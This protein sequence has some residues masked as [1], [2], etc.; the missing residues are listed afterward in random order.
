M[1]K[2]FCQ[3]NGAEMYLVKTDAG[4]YDRETGERMFGMVAHCPNERWWKFWESHGDV[5]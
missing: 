3:R 4:F 1:A 2:Q 5:R